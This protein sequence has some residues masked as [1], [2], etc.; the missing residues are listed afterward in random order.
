MQGANRRKVGHLERICN[1]ADAVL[2]RKSNRNTKCQQ[3]LTYGFAVPKNVFAYINKGFNNTGGRLLM[4][5]LA[6]KMV[7]LPFMLPPD[8]AVALAWDTLAKYSLFVIGGSRALPI[9]LYFFAASLKSLFRKIKGKT[10][11]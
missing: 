4:L 10:N 3:P 9:V 11:D 1:A 7:T 2:W 5:Y 8:R 6:A